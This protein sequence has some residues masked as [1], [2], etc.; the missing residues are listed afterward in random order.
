MICMQRALSAVVALVLS[1]T[2]TAAQVAEAPLASDTTAAITAPDSAPQLQPPPLVEELSTLLTAASAAWDYVQRQY[3][4]GTGLV[5]SVAGYQYATTWDIASGLAALY[6]AHEL[7]L[8]PRDEYESRMRK[9]LG[10][11]RRMP[12]FQNTVFNKNYSTRTG[13]TAGRSD[14]EAA[15]GYGWSAMDIGRLLIW[16]KIIAVNHPWLAEDAERVVA[17]LRLSELVKDGYLWGASHDR[18]GNIRRYVEGRIPY[19]QYAAHGFAL[20][21]HR[22]EQALSL[23]ANALPIEV[24]DV[25]L[26][27]DRRGHDHL[28]S[29]P[30]VLMGLEVGWSPEA[31]DLA[32]RLLRVQ[33]ERH[34]RTGIVTVVSE[35]AIPLAP[36]FF[37]YYTVNYH[38]EQ[39]AV[40]AQTVESALPE[41]RWVS[42][43]AAYGWHA[44]LPS[45]YTWLAVQTVGKARHPERGWSSGVFEQSGRPTGSENINTA[46]VILE[47]VLYHQRK[48]P[49]LGTTSGS[50][51][52]SL[53][54]VPPAPGTSPLTQGD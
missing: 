46:A 11:L 2:S 45:P 49:L 50:S 13:G 5:N 48:R 4:P 6:C 15:A 1:A 23:E 53:L 22:A 38:G 44:L 24:M 9:A 20:W 21:G 43:K 39:F 28:T 30:L 31:A 18:G 17:R 8:L 33:E 34:R 3:Q 25:P 37:Y 51:T 42:A 19:E 35:D 14:R 27:A 16:L 47:A 52:A 54:T 26:V 10:T 29:E 7:G 41:P 12:L 36:H 40:V 32:A